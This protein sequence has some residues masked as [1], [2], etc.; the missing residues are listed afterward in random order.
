MTAPLTPDAIKTYLF[1]SGWNHVASV[2]DLAEVW[3]RIA[4]EE[5]QEVVIPLNNAADYEI[6][7]R[8]LVTVLAGYEL[9]SQKEL[10]R[11]VQN[12]SYDQF[13]IRVEH[14]DVKD[15]TIPIN[16]GIELTRNARE[17]L[18]AAGSAVLSKRRTFSG[19]QPVEVIDFIKQTRL[20]QTEH[21][22]YVIN[23]FCRI[24]VPSSERSAS[25]DVAVSQSLNQALG[26]LKKSLAS[27]RESVTPVEFEQTLSAG[28]SSNLCDALLN[29]FGEQSQRKITISFNPGAGRRIFRPEPY[30]HSFPPDDSTAI[31]IASDYLKQIYTLRNIEISGYIKR[32]DREL[33][34]NRGNIWIHTLLPNLQEKNVQVELPGNEYIEAIHAHETNQLVSCIGDVVI[35]PRSAHLIEKRQFKVLGGALPFNG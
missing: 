1:D 10:L 22:S 27:F 13:S 30:S 8:E 3:R 20:G 4:N 14:Y 15:G 26:A 9:V 19:R 24:E 21:G 5:Q 11:L 17:L 35:S 6:R 34:A 32:L 25:F 16:D 2:D 23:V 28:V 7:M 12:V 29:L 33:D 18:I 31:Q